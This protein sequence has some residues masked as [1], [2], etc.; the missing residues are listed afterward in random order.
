MPALSLGYGGGRRLRQRRMPR[1]VSIGRHSRWYDLVH[2]ATQ[3]RS[4]QGNIIV[5]DVLTQRGIPDFPICGESGIGDSLFPDSGQI[6][7]RGFPPRFPV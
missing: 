2:E 5:H 6:G 3:V 4:F 1:P 7:N